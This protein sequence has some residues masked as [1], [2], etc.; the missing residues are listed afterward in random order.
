M[1]ICAAHALHYSND[2]LQRY[3]SSGGGTVYV[4]SCDVYVE[5]ELYDANG[6]FLDGLIGPHHKIS[7]GRQLPVPD[8]S[9]RTDAAPSWIIA[10]GL[11]LPSPFAWTGSSWVTLVTVI[12]PESPFRS[13]TPITTTGTN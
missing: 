5:F 4:T 10:S 8:R 1:V 6:L 13:V 3:G 12:I 11:L 9:A 2:C 7:R